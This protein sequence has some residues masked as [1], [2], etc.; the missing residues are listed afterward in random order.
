MLTVSRPGRFATLRRKSW[1]NLRRAAAYLR[2]P[3]GMTCL[4]CG[5]LALADGEV[6]PANRVLLGANG[7]AGCPPIN[8]L[9]C[10]KKLW[11]SYDLTYFDDSRDGLFAELRERRRPCVGF[12]RY[13]PVRSPREHLDLEESKRARSEKI[14]IG[15]LGAAVG[16]LAAIL[17]KWLLK[18]F[19]L[20]AS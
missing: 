18:Y 9:R 2:H 6:S 12:L 16:I 13:R 5:F 17:T 3:K 11:I 10:T 14:I 19:G 15:L 7:E 1:R 8:K 20:N 4:N